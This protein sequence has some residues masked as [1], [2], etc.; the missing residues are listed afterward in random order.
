VLAA[1]LVVANFAMA[2]G[3]I[4][5]SPPPAE[6]QTRGA[7]VLAAGS[8]SCVSDCQVRHDLCRIKRKGSPSCDVERQQCLLKC[9]QQKKK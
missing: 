4:A 5:Q 1:A 2:R 9:L 3:A 7:S 8:G 6:P